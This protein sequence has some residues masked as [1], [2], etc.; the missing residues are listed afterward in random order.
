MRKRAKMGGRKRGVHTASSGLILRRWATA[1]EWWRRETLHTHPGDRLTDHGNVLISICFSLSFLPSFR[2]YC[3]PPRSRASD[4][5]FRLSAATRFRLVSGHEFVFPCINAMTQKTL[6]TKFG[7]SKIIEK[8]FC[9]ARLPRLSPRSDRFDIR[10][11]LGQ[12]NMQKA[13]SESHTR[14]NATQHNGV[15]LEVHQTE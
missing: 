11:A 6:N 2:V 15:A 12:L 4:L 1:T 9:I 14:L 10:K 5:K 13:D 8:S 3:W 7:L